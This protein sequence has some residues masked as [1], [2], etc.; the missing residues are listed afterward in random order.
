MTTTDPA[1]LSHEVQRPDTLALLVAYERG[2]I[3]D[4]DALGLLA[5][6]IRTGLAWTLQGHYGRTAAHLIEAGHISE[7]GTVLAYL[8]DDE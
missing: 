6:L 8:E 5:D 7:D 4:A 1:P 3:S 2:D